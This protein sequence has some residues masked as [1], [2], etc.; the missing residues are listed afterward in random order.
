METGVQSVERIDFGSLSLQDALDL[1]VLM[2]EEARDRYE[3]FSRI[4]GGRYAGDASDMCR[5]MAANE[6]KHGAQL[7]ERRRAMFGVAPRHLSRDQLDDVEAP[8]LGAPRVFMSARQMMLVALQSE[9]KAEAFFQSALEYVRDPQVR[10]LFLELA[11]EERQHQ[12][13]VESCLQR[14]PRGPDVEAEEADEPGSDP[15]N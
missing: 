6:A 9:R 7:T 8:D 15:G 14:L 11:A 5:M 4:V 13:L 2:E 12:V 10:D 3:L 1:A